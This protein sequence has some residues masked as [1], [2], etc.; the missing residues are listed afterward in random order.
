VELRFEWDSNKA[1]SNL[2]KHGVS[3]DEARE[4]FADP[5]SLT[6]EDPDHSIDEI[7]ILIIGVSNRGRLL[8]VSHTV[9]DD[10]IRLIG[11]RRATPRERF[12][13]EEDPH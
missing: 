9:D 1:T 2:A 3:F 6:S 8:V 11:A 12:E 10:R 13:Y 5:L 7:R 4:V